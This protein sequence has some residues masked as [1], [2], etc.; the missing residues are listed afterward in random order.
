M[1]TS[2]TPEMR[3]EERVLN[4]RLY[5]TSEMEFKRLTTHSEFIDDIMFEINKKKFNVLKKAMSAS[6]IFVNSEEHL[7]FPRPINHKLIYIG[8]FDFP[9]QFKAPKLIDKTVLSKADKFILVSFGSVT[10]TELMPEKLKNAVLETTR[11]FPDIIFLVKDDVKNGIW[12]ENYP[13]VYYQKWFPQVDL[14]N[15][16]K[17]IAMITHAGMNSVI[18]IAYS[19]VPSLLLPQYADQFRN[20]ALFTYRKTGITLQKHETTVESITEALK[21][22][23]HEPEIRQNAQKLASVIKSKPFSAKERLLKYVNFTVEHGDKDYLDLPGRH[24]NFVERYSLDVIAKALGWTDSDLEANL[25]KFY[26]NL[27]NL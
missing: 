27:N 20:A 18:Q 22:I 4:L 3:F 2:M 24:L 13:N 8:G 14:L 15:F 16:D 6:C 7:E 17:T 1:M 9:Q 11:N 19:G 23:I 26:K 12:D 25:K 5:L 21:K 10:K